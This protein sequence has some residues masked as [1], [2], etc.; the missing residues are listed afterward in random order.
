MFMV[1]NINKWIVK[2]E[3]IIL[4]R[5]LRQ[6]MTTRKLMFLFTLAAVMALPASLEAQ[7]A[8]RL[9]AIL[10]KPAVNYGEAAIFA[11]EA[12]EQAFFTDPVEAFNYAKERKWLP[13]KAEAG[14]VARLDG[15]SL[16][17]V[18]AFEVKGGMFF[19][20]AQNSHY[21]YREL[22][23]MSIIL[24]DTDPAMKVPGEEFL[25][26]LG[27]LL[28]RKEDVVFITDTNAAEARLSNVQFQANST[29]LL[30]SEKVKLRNIAEIL[31]ESPGTKILIAGHTALAD[32]EGARQRTSLERAKAVA[33]YL[34]SLGA[35]TGKEVIIEGYGS[36]R[37]IAD[38]GTQDGM[39]VN[40]RVEITILDD[41]GSK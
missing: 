21:A 18:K 19:R 9:A 39:A 24:G 5:I 37:P 7:T 36:D 35:L 6:Q 14:G 11:L 31:K 26:M 8:A 41:G 16:L 17:L 28:D 1:K 4:R 25:F 29:V 20:I 12:A 40:R 13:K 3:Q 23:Y 22:V 30:E 38:N 2:N 32:S 27:Q 15:I 10:D 33:D 34:G